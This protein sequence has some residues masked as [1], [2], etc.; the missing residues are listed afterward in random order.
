MRSI[1]AS[2]ATTELDDDELSELDTADEME[3]LDERLELDKTLED[4]ELDEF[5]LGA[6]DDELDE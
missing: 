5:E 4:E 1:G 3:E 2:V 6:T